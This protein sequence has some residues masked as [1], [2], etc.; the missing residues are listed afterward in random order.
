MAQAA[1][2][3]LDRPQHEVA[4]VLR[5]QAPA[6]LSR[7]EELVRIIGAVAQ[8]FVGADDVDSGCDADSTDIVTWW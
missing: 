6:V 8:R 3:E 5:H 4:A 7:K 2:V 1:L